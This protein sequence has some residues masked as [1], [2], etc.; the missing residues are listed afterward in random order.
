MSDTFVDANIDPSLLAM[1]PA[2]QMLQ[3]YRAGGSTTPAPSTPDN[4]DGMDQDRPEGAPE[5]TGFPPTSSS[6][7]PPG[8]SSLITFGNLV[9][10]KVKL[11]DKSTVAFDQFVRLRSLEERNIMLFAQILEL[12]DITRQNEKADQWVI[13]SDLGLKVK[14]YTQAFFLS[15]DISAYRGLKQAEHILTSMREC[16]ISE[17]PPDAEA[18][19]VKS[20]LSRIGEKGTHYRNIIKTAVMASLEPGS[21]LE[22]IAELT[23]K[24]IQGTTIQATFQLYIRVA[25][26]IRNESRMGVVPGHRA[27]GGTSAMR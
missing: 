6:L 26:I 13:S 21:A 20:V 1:N 14:T 24:L 12:V 11:S 3:M 19:N 27:T 18:T 15:P 5:G 8:S 7:I 17:L 16:N 23:H 9:K 25:F 22:N 4:D 10:H 2:A